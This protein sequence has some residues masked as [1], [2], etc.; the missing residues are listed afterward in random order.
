[1]TVVPI[2]AKVKPM[3]KKQFM[4]KAKEYDLPASGVISILMHMFVDGEIK[5]SFRVNVDDTYASF[6]THKD[7]VEVHEPIENVIAT[8]E[9]L[10]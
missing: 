9:R 2:T 8:L 3:L 4:A 6:Y 5:P 10:Q 7:M 1:M